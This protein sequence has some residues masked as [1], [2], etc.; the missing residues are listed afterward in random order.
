MTPPSGFAAA[1]L[2]GEGVAVPMPR[3]GGRRL[4]AVVADASQLVRPK[5]AVMVLAT[6]VAAFWLVAGPPADVGAFVAL[7]VGTALVAASS[8]IANQ[9]VERRT[10]RLMPR[11]ARRPVA[12]GRLGVGPSSLL[13]AVPLVAV[14]AVIVA[15]AGRQAAAA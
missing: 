2:A 1:E 8:S 11:T 12:S 10:D 13:A 6:V 9:V 15:A 14:T 3:L 5:I 4:A 7:L